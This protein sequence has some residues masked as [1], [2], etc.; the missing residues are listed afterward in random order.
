MKLLRHMSDNCRLGLVLA[1]VIAL[2]G[3]CQ[4]AWGAEI[5]R[6]QSFERGDTI[7]FGQ[8]WFVKNLHPTKQ[9]L[10]PDSLPFMPTDSNADSG[11]FWNEAIPMAMMGF[12]FHPQTELRG[13]HILGIWSGSTGGGYKIFCSG[14]SDFGYS[15]TDSTI[16]CPINT[17][18]YNYG[19]IC[20]SDSLIFVVWYGGSDHGTY[21]RK[22]TVATSVWSNIVTIAE[23]IE[24]GDPFTYRPDI[25]NS[26][27]ELYVT[28]E[29]SD[30]TG[31]NQ[32]FKKS[33][34]Y[35][36]TWFGERVVGGVAA[37]KGAEIAYGD[38]VIHVVRGSGG[39]TEVRYDRSTDLGETWSDDSFIS[40]LDSEYSQ[41]PSVA[42]DPYGNVYATWFDYK[43]SP[44]GDKGYLFYRR[45][46][47]NGTT[48]EPIQYL[49]TQ[50]TVTWS[51]ITADSTGVYVV[52]TDDRTAYT[53][54]Y[55][56][57]STDRGVTWSEELSQSD[58]AGITTE[59]EI[60]V[61]RGYLSVS[62][63]LSKYLGDHYFVAVMHKLGGRFVPGDA[64]ADGIV[65]VSDAV[66]LISYIFSGSI[67]PIIYNAGD[68]ECSGIVN[69]SDVVY[70][71]NYIFA[72]GSPPCGR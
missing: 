10:L 46:T 22:E 60:D 8:N 25:T 23:Y 71:I 7:F 31:W 17:S 47:N 16:L 51:D 53:Q 50:P 67:P 6:P 20:G 48:W 40:D 65:N 57:M 30:H 36:D 4:A 68:V 28:Y 54:T 62:G 34:D 38:G 11:V 55:F 69:I 32:R 15:W 27:T 64:D 35:G 9:P 72:S 29:G 41:W 44:N 37:G 3:L 14:S 42:A 39:F 13:R 66:Y 63:R 18:N 70:L 19:N 33:T 21:F 61:C 59:P 26:T 43:N 24:G 12:S 58:P 45:S 5:D 52:W 49:S 1:A 56:R 2:I